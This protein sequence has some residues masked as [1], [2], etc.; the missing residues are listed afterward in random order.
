MTSHKRPPPP[1][2]RLAAP[3]KKRWTSVVSTFVL[4]EHHLKILQ[5]CCESWDTMSASGAPDAWN[6]L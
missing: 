4:E 3:T 1:P 5:A 6:D 2:Q